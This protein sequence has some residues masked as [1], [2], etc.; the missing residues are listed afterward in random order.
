[1]AAIV[2]SEMVSFHDINA[3]VEIWTIQ[4]CCAHADDTIEMAL[5]VCH[6]MVEQFLPELTQPLKAKCGEILNLKALNDQ[7]VNFQDKLLPPERDDLLETQDR[8]GA[9]IHGEHCLTSPS[10]SQWPCVI[11]FV[12]MMRGVMMPV[13]GRPL[14]T[15]RA[16]KN[17][18]HLKFDLCQPCQYNR[19]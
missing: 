19:D 5:E 14:N 9:D 8:S 12:K 2:L 4:T 7:L 17:F 1:M 11:Y 18:R 16:H 15:H 13:I 6:S 3:Q 10:H